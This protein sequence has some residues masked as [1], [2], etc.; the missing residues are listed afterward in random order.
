MRYGS[1]HTRTPSSLRN[2]TPRQALPTRAACLAS[3]WK[4]LLCHAHSLPCGETLRLRVRK[5]LEIKLRPGGGSYHLGGVSS[6]LNGAG[7]AAEPMYDLSRLAQALGCEPLRPWGPW[8]ARILS[9]DRP[10]LAVGEL[11]ASYAVHGAHVGIRQM[12]RVKSDVTEKG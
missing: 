11:L 5:R 9:F 2:N 1:V 3:F 4:D 7:T 6:P 10:P 8:G 12:P